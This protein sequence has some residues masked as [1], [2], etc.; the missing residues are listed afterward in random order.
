[1]CV[2]EIVDLVLSLAVFYLQV[3]FL[4]QKSADSLEPALN[5]VI[6][7]ELTWLFLLRAF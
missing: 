7:A 2:W 6:A 4:K 1:V 5:E 3:L